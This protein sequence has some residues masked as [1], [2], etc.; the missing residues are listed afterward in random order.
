MAFN[1]SNNKTED[2]SFERGSPINQTAK[3][4]VKTTS[5]QIQKQGDDT[6]KAILNQL[7]GVSDSP[8]QDEQ[9][10]GNAQSAVPTNF[11]KPATGQTAGNASNS[12]PSQVP[13]EQVQMEKVRRELFSNYS[14][15]YKSAQNGAQ[16]IITNLDLEMEK[17]RKEREQKELQR[18]QE[19]EEEERRKKEEEER[20]KQELLVPAGKKTGIM[21]S[22]KQQQPIAVRLAATK[23]EINR[24]TSG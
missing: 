6:A 3:T 14:K 17:A 8:V 15:N 5:T 16:N 18:K 20:Q 23:T 9:G 13:E 11:S 10:G 22:K 21:L 12:N 2:T 7:Y 1:F 19:E 24:G 4:F